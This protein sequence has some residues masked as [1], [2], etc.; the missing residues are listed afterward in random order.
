MLEDGLAD[1]AV[2]AEGAH[3]SA[4]SSTITHWPRSLLGVTWMF[5]PPF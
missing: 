5:L 3:E 1:G 2:E 4:F